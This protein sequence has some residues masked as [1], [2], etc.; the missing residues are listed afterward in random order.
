MP[1][2]DYQSLLSAGNVACFTNLPPGEWRVIQLA[3]LQAI[4][5]QLNPSVSTDYQSLL[6]SANVACY[7]NLP[8]GLQNVLVLALLQLIAQNIGS[9]GG[10]GTGATFGNYGG[11]QPSFT[12]SSGTGLAVDTSTNNFWDYYGGSWHQ[13]V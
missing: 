9:G 6:N 5:Q 1:A 8:P 3:L 10:G 2:T 4:V 13:L 12:P 7:T 11:G